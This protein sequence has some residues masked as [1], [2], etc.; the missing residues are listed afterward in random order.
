MRPNSDLSSYLIRRPVYKQDDFDYEYALSSSERIDKASASKTTRRVLYSNLL[1]PV[2]VLSLFSIVSTLAEYNFRGK[3]ASDL[4]SGL[5]VG[6]MNIPSGLAYGALTS[7][8][9]SNGL[10]TSLFPGLAYALFGTSR[11]LS[12]GTF[13]V[14]SLMVCAAIG[15]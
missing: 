8:S 2:R 1:S 3:L 9:P 14:V 6:V 7:L 10:Y 13:A 12:V 5:T 11:H 4:V 15:K